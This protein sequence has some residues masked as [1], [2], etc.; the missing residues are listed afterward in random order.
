MEKVHVDRIPKRFRWRVFMVPG[1]EKIP[2][3]EIAAAVVDYA[4]KNSIPLVTGIRSGYID[5]LNRHP[6]ICRPSTGSE[7][8]ARR[9]K[10]GAIPTARRIAEE[11]LVCTK[12]GPVEPVGKEAWFFFRFGEGKDQPRYRTLE[13]LKNYRRTPLDVSAIDM[14]RDF[15]PVKSEDTDSGYECAYG[16]RDIPFSMNRLEVATCD[17]FQKNYSGAWDGEWQEVFFAYRD[18]H[19]RLGVSRHLPPEYKAA[20]P[21]SSFCL[22]N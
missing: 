11:V 7:L 6:E 17:G 9:C 10:G 3:S 2:Q 5:E 13:D 20:K 22:Y 4:K 21:R 16:D 14:M 12:M 19:G 8:F 18:K 15:V 1:L